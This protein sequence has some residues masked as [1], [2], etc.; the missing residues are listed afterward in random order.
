M[1]Q[2]CLRFT[3]PVIHRNFLWKILLD[4]TPIYT[5][6]HDFVAMQRKKE[7]HDLEKA[8]RVTKIVDENSKPHQTLLIMWLLRKRRAKLDINSQLESSLFR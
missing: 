3:V 1:K 5:E 4:I 8:L 6:S 7:F 2:F